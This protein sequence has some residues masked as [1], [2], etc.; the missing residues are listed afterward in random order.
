M[1]LN[2]LITLFHHLEPSLKLAIDGDPIEPITAVKVEQGQLVCQSTDEQPLT[3]ERF[4]NLKITN[5]DLTVVDADHT[6][7]FGFRQS[8]HWL[9]FK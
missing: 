3:I 4:R 2:E 6:R 1:E 9:L 8:N 7:L 5:G